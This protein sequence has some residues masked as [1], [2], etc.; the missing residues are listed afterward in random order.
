MRRFVTR[1]NL[2]S[3]LE[4]RDPPIRVGL[5]GRLYPHQRVRRIPLEIEIGVG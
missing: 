5:E 1:T 4:D 3:L 2:D